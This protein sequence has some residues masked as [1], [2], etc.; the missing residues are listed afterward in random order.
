MYKEQSN[1]PVKGMGLYA[2]GGG[3][4]IPYGCTTVV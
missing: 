3:G 4:G 1:L 2:C